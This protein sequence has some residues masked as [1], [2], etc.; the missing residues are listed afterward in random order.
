MGE[1]TGKDLYL[2]LNSSNFYSSVMH[3][4]NQHFKHTLNKH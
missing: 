4:K 2:F 1:L 3:L